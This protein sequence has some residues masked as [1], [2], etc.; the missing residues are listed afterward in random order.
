MGFLGRRDAS[1]VVARSNRR[2]VT[3][4]CNDID[5][6]S[7]CKT[8]NVG[9]VKSII[10]ESPEQLHVQMQGR[11]PLYYACQCGH[12]EIVK[13]LLQAGCTDDEFKSCHRAALSPEIRKLLK[14]YKFVEHVLMGNSMLLSLDAAT[15]PPTSMHI[16]NG[17][18][19]RPA[20]FPAINQANY[21]LLDDSQSLATVPVNNTT[22]SSSLKVVPFLEIISPVNA[23]EIVSRLVDSDALEEMCGE[24]GPLVQ[25]SAR[26]IEITMSGAVEVQETT[27][28]MLADHNKKWSRFVWK[29]PSN[30]NASK[31]TLNVSTAK[32]FIHSLQKSPKKQFQDEPHSR[33]NDETVD[34]PSTSYSRE[35][36]VVETSSNGDDLEVTLQWDKNTDLPTNLGSTIT[37]SPWTLLKRTLFSPRKA[38]NMQPSSLNTKDDEVSA[39][40]HLLDEVV[41]CLPSVLVPA[42]GIVP[43]H[44][45]IKEQLLESVE[46]AASAAEPP[47][48]VASSESLKPSLQSINR[49]TPSSS[50][51]YSFN[52]FAT[53]TSATTNDGDIKR[54][55]IPIVCIPVTS[56]ETKAVHASSQR[57]DGGALVELEESKI[58]L[59]PVIDEDKKSEKS[60][61]PSAIGWNLFFFSNLRSTNVATAGGPSDSEMETA[62]T[63]FAAANIKEARGDAVHPEI[64]GKEHVELQSVS[65]VSGNETSI[66]SVSGKASYVGPDRPGCALQC[67]ESD[68]TEPHPR[69]V[70]HMTL[71]ACGCIGEEIMVDEYSLTTLSFDAPLLPKVL[72]GRSTA[73][74]ISTLS[75]QSRDL[76]EVT[77]TNSPKAVEPMR[78]EEEEVLLVESPQHSLSREH[79]STV[80]NEVSILPE[81]KEMGNS[82]EIKGDVRR[83]A[84][85]RSNGSSVEEDA[86]SLVSESSDSFYK[87]DDSCSSHDDQTRTSSEHTNDMV[88]RTA[89]DRTFEIHDTWCGPT[90]Y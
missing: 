35:D 89:S 78:E 72:R 31:R 8:G 5:L 44:A 76:N 19:E 2:E 69:G 13:L 90:C 33:E 14:Q 36:E 67:T 54:V 27:D 6:W 56:E 80:P 49:S 20:P 29:F 86:P 71:E 12:F 25:S 62:S 64:T 87:G 4:R 38:T 3:Q 85:V 66:V 48:E 88:S 61:P 79:S 42:K 26:T 52:S 39:T 59:L 77:T 17:D 10:E 45:P 21:S 51:T 40:E 43:S 15:E 55:L 30:Q 28:R 23:D 68:N 73:T 58:D 57:N 47:M 75:V 9:F 24:E 65:S 32:R 1:T 37:K 22:A 84:R 70:V 11:T 50:T 53:T 34:T 74:N 16:R 63:T 41:E 7:A 83:T 81:N 18:E 46:C 82:P 60:A